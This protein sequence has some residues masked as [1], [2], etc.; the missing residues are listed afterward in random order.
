MLEVAQHQR[1]VDF[2]GKEDQDPFSHS[3]DQRTGQVDHTEHD[4]ERYEQ[5]LQPVGQHLVHDRLV[6][7]GGHDA[8]QCQDH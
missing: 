2:N 1:D 5:V 6:E 4:N 3:R 7:N 8:D